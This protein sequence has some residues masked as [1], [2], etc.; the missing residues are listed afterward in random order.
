MSTLVEAQLNK[1]Y[2]V[3]EINLEEASK[4]HLSDLGLIP[5]GKVALVSHSKGNGIIV[6]HNSRVALNDS[7]LKQILISE[8]AVQEEV[9]LSLDQLDVG[10]KAKVVSIYG[11]GAI[12]RRLMDMGLTRNVE[13]LIRKRAPLG[14]PIEINLRGYEL[15]LRKNEAELV[16][17]RKEVE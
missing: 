15:T 8:E 10:D 1:V 13:V 9:W 2:T 12:R 6:L 3:T 16:L 11:K 7:V 4:K 17:V 5:G 14:D